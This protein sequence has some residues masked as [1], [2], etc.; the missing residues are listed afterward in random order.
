MTALYT[1]PIALKVVDSDN[2]VQTSP[3]VNVIAELALNYPNTAQNG[4]DTS[5][6]WSGGLVS[7]SKFAPILPC[8]ALS[9]F[10]QPPYIA[11]ILT[12]DVSSLAMIQHFVPFLL[13]PL[14]SSLN[15]TISTLET[16]HREPGMSI[17]LR[18]QCLCLYIKSLTTRASRLREIM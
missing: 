4:V 3:Q 17:L 9:L 5:F 12:P 10:P 15:T 11:Y 1:P 2:S 6:S 16:R 18:R 8:Q 14:F 13:N 7:S